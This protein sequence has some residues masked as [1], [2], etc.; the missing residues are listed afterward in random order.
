MKRILILISLS[1]ICCKNTSDPFENIAFGKISKND[2]LKEMIKNKT[3]KIF[4][5]YKNRPNEISS[6]GYVFK[7]KKNE[8]EMGVYLNEE[9]YTSNY[10]F[11]SL[12]RIEFKIG[13]DTIEQGQIYR[14]NGEISKEKVDNLFDSFLEING[15]PDS[16]LIINE[17]T[18]EDFFSVADKI[19]ERYISGKKA[20]WLKNNYKIIFEIPTLRK[21]KR[22]I[23]QKPKERDVKI[24]YEMKNYKEYWISFQDSITFSSK[25]KD[26]V[27]VSTKDCMWSN[28]YDKYNDTKLEI[29]FYQISRRD[30]SEQKIKAIRFDLIIEDSFKEE[31][32]KHENLTI[33]L[34]SGLG[35][36]GDLYLNKI[37]SV[38]FNSKKDSKLVRLKNYSKNNKV[39]IICKVKLILFENGSIIKD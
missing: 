19:D 9:R 8:Q 36:S 15:K 39:N 26:L 38:K 10:S 3:F 16:L 22:I 7:H 31:L 6:I 12:R 18:S 28:V 32:Y 33:E 4:K 21:A 14:N 11:G 25:P 17:Y 2:F 35:H 37:F 13:K 1:L 34:K 20:I 27:W 24:V 29:E 23:Y 30:L 5:E